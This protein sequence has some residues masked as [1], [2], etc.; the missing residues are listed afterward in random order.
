[1][2]CNVFVQCPNH[3]TLF[4]KLAHP[5]HVCASTQALHASHR[6]CKAYIHRNTFSGNSRFRFKQE[7]AA[8]RYTKRPCAAGW[9][10]TSVGSCHTPHSREGQHAALVCAQPPQPAAHVLLH[11][12]L[13]GAAV[14]LQVL[15][16][17][18][19]QAHMVS[20]YLAG[21]PSSRCGI[22]PAPALSRLAPSPQAL[23]HS[24][25]HCLV[26]TQHAAMAAPR[27]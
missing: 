9:C 11:Q 2:L 26:R 21:A 4:A 15:L 6:C 1:M 20:W 17:A 8:S 10:R 12:R 16:C 14:L 7:R 13:D 27:H 24:A 22:S 19:G 3:L 23:E 5:V 18:G 25:S